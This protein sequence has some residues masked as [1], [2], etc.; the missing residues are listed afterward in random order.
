M[1]MASSSA[2]LCHSHGGTTAIPFT[3]TDEEQIP[4]PPPP[5]PCNHSLSTGDTDAFLSHL[6]TRLSLPPPTLTPVLPLRSK[7]KTITP[8]VISLREPN[9][10]LFLLA[11]TE[12]GFFHVS[13]H[14]IP[15]HLHE[16]YLQNY[17]S[18]R[19][20]SDT[21]DLGCRGSNDA[22]HINM[23][24]TDDSD[25]EFAREMER[26]GLKVLDILFEEKG[27]D[28]GTQTRCL[29]CVSMN[30]M[31]KSS[32]EKVSKEHL[33]SCIVQLTYE[34]RGKKVPIAVV[35]DSGKWVPE[36]AR[37]EVV[38][39]TIGE[40][41]QVWSNGRFKK[42]RSLPQ[43]SPSSLHQSKEPGNVLVTLLITL[44]EEG[45]LTPLMPTIQDANNCS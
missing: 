15:S 33:G 41:A 18:N 16:T 9:R 44:P 43:P 40:V 14:D 13:D 35:D 25:N 31:E 4:S 10:E 38:L 12:L 5:T 7:Q 27:L 17:R 34:G 39:V 45:T 42:I 36:E 22:G 11:A 23:F 19:V 32:M 28:L 20:L 21:T 30:K 1:A 2:T 3:L 8:P 29:M 24:E 6:L 26:V 37:E